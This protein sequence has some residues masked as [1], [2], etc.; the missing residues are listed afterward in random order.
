MT[1]DETSESMSSNTNNG[2]G[3]SSTTLT[4][5]LSG[6]IGCAHGERQ[7]SHAPTHRDPG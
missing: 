7:E 4:V 1:K 3:T 5:E 2:N 6:C